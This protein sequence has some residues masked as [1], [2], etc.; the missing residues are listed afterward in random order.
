MQS[1]I[2]NCGL[3]VSHLNPTVD[4]VA[5][6]SSAAGQHHP[7]QH[8][9]AACSGEI[10][11]SP[12]DTTGILSQTRSDR[13][14]EIFWR[15]ATRGPECDFCW[16]LLRSLCWRGWDGDGSF[17]KFLCCQRGKRE[18]PL[19][20][21][22]MCAWGTTPRGDRR[23]SLSLQLGVLLGW[24]WKEATQ[25]LE[26][27]WPLCSLLNMT[28]PALFAHLCLMPGYLTFCQHQRLCNGTP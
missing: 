22:C 13:L 5:A 7:D 15:V 17:S 1:I 28:V 24:G 20:V 16:L 21:L 10:R 25:E 6:C 2:S 23:L 26:E 8:S 19:V 4:S 12:T 18:N 3:S 14:Q 11:Q 27:W 9:A